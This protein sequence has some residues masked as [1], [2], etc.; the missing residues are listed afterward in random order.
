MRARYL[1]CVL[2]ALT[3]CASATAA[4][5]APRTG[6][7]FG[8]HRQL[9][10]VQL[11]RALAA[12]GILPQRGVLAPKPTPTVA[13]DYPGVVGGGD[14]QLTG[15]QV[16]G[17]ARAAGFPESVI[18]T[19]VAIAFRE[20]R[21]NAHAVNLSSGACGLWQLYPCPGLAALGPMVNAQLAYIKYQASGLA[22]WGGSP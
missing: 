1:A 16:A 22:P 20:S 21:Y 14:Y 17:Y 9:P 15:D 4:T 7:G 19:M 8:H 2:A 3:A 10:N 18:P 6:S 11:A 13:P 12:P 5:E